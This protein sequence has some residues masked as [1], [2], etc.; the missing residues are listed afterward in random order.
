MTVEIQPRLRVCLRSA[1]LRD[2]RPSQATCAPSSRISSRQLPKNSQLLTQSLQ[3]SNS[4]MASKTFV[5]TL[6]TASKQ[7][8]SSQT[9]PKRSFTSV[10]IAR[11]TVTAATRAPFTSPVQQQT[12]G[13][14]T[15]DFAGSKEQVFG[16]KVAGTSVN[17]ANFY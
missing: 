6:R 1:S 11:P 8:I 2:R 10:L 14:K 3:T 16:K 4:K 13:V 15:I 5:R 17:M 9:V 12:R 7:K